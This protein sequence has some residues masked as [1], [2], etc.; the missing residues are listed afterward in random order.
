ME[1]AISRV[2][3]SLMFGLMGMGIVGSVIVVVMGRREH[4]NRVKTLQRQNQE[5][6][7]EGSR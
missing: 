5:R 6:R 4:K 1:K 2:R 3:I 7:Q